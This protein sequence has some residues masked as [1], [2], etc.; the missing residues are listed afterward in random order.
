MSSEQAR[1][2]PGGRL[3]IIGG[4]QLGRM[5]ALAAARLGIDCHI[6]SPD[7]DSPAFR[8]AA[9]HSCAAYD[10]V[11]ALTDGRFDSG[12]RCLAILI[13]VIAECPLDHRHHNFL[14]H[15]FHVPR[16]AIRLPSACKG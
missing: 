11:G 15:C 10:D 5:T 9:A 3:G 14:S 16:S 1:I 13:T 2:G 12:D 4:G 7:P 8:V 6:F